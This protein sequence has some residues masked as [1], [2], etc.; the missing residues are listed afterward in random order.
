MSYVAQ[1]LSIN[2]KLW[3][4]LP[5]FRKTAL[6]C[7]T[8]KGIFPDFSYRKTAFLRTTYLRKELGSVWRKCLTEETISPDYIHYKADFEFTSWKLNFKFT[9]GSQ[10][11][12]CDLEDIWG[13]WYQALRDL[14]LPSGVRLAEVAAFSIYHRYILECE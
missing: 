14:V 4:S 11:A 8:N 6:G 9:H 5:F 2:E 7:L 10:D 12:W 13:V 1:H 3:L